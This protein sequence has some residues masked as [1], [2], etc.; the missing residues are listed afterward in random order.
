MALF[1][2]VFRSL[3]LSLSLSLLL[4]SEMKREVTQ[5][6]GHKMKENFSSQKTRP[7]QV[8][9]FAGWCC[10]LS[11]KWLLL[12]YFSRFLSSAEWPGLTFFTSFPPLSLTFDTLFSFLQLIQR[13]LLAFQVES[14]TPTFSSPGLT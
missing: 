14:L 4:E 12:I 11:P 3:S 6:P 2:L 7:G 8:M 1:A 5:W 9:I 10:R 13:Q